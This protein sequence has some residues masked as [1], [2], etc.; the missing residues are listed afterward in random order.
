MSRLHRGRRL[1]Q[2]ALRGYAV[3]QGI[4]KDADVIPFPS[5]ERKP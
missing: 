4:V 3:E 2:K 1:L 5:A